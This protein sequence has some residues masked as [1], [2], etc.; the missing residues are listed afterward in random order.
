MSIDIKLKTFFGFQIYSLHGMLPNL[1]IGKEVFLHKNLS[2]PKNTCDYD[3]QKVQ[4]MYLLMAA[5]T[6]RHKNKKL[7]KPVRIPLLV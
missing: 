2:G 3:S 1:L 7:E 4:T 5:K 6:T